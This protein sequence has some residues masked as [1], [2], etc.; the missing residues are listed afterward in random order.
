LSKCAAGDVGEKADDTK[1]RSE[2]PVA[3]FPKPNGY[4]EAQQAERYDAETHPVGCHVPLA[5]DIKR[6]CIDHLGYSPGSPFN[7][8]SIS[9]AGMRRKAR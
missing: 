1:N 9:S 8:V 2:A 7:K 4:D 3:S 6:S 5:D